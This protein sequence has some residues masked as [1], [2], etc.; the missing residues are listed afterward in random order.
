MEDPDAPAAA[1]P[2]RRR[3]CPAIVKRALWDDVVNYF[4]TYRKTLGMV[5]KGDFGEGVFQ[6][7]K[8]SGS[9]CNKSSWIVKA[10]KNIIEKRSGSGLTT[11]CECLVPMIDKHGSFN[12]LKDDVGAEGLTDALKGCSDNMRNQIKTALKKSDGIVMKTGGIL[13]KTSGI[14]K[15]TGSK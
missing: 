10:V 13:K 6:Q 2:A 9:W 14:L 3:S 12:N 8:N 4:K 11:I 5:V 1:S 7:L 15:K